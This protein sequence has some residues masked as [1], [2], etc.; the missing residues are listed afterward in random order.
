MNWLAQAALPPNFWR[1]PPNSPSLWIAIS[2]AF[3]AGMGLI[4]VLMNLPSNAR[5]PIVWT[6]TFMAGLYWVTYYF[7]PKPL[8]YQAGEIARNGFEGVGIW[9][10]EANPVIANISNIVGAVL[11]G[12][13]TY[14]LVHIH[15]KRLMRKGKDWQFSLVLLTCMVL[16]LILGYWNYHLRETLKDLAPDMS[17]WPAPMLGF[18]LLFDGLLQQMDAAMFSLIAFFILSAAYRAFRI[19]SIESTVLMA[20]ALVVM[21]SLMGIVEFAWSEGIVSKFTNGDPASFMNNFRL[22]VVSDWVKNTIQV[23]SLRALD[24]GIAL[25]ALAMGLR[26]WLGLE[27]GG[28]TTQ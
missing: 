5:R 8:D 13:G 15:T 18:D 28:V 24:F 9:L 25:G 21:L 11:L 6:V 1:L 2:L 4:L 27:R 22:G 26:I 10:Q 20:S 17:N 12:L 3:L 16:M 23:P 14:G 7:Y 19:R